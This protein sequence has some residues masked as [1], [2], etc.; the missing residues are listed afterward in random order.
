MIQLN[1]FTGKSTFVDPSLIER[2]VLATS[3]QVAQYYA[4]YLSSVIDYEMNNFISYCY[5]QNYNSD[6]TLVFLKG[7]QFP[8]VI[9]DDFR[10]ILR[11]KEEW[12]AKNDLFSSQLLPEVKALFAEALKLL[13]SFKQP[14]AEPCTPIPTDE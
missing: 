10:Q 8:L 11:K 2:F 3:K 1:L 9:V 12:E 14:P 4:S 13:E 6:V 7:K 5:G